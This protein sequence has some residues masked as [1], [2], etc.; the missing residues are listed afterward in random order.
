[1]SQMHAPVAHAFCLS[2]FLIK[3]LKHRF[4]LFYFPEIK[5]QIYA[6]NL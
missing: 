2:F 1:M 4:V 5:T 3:I 6:H